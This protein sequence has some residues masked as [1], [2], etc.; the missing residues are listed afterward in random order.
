MPSGTPQPSLF[1]VAT[2]SKQRLDDNDVDG[3]SLGSLSSGTAGEADPFCPRRLHTPRNPT[4]R[5]EQIILALG[6]A[7][8]VPFG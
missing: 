2:G 3:G 8:A 6:R 1:L 4:V 5:T 7:E